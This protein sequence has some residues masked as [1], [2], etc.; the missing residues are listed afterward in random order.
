MSQSWDTE[1][2]GLVNGEVRTETSAVEICDQSN[3]CTLTFAFGRSFETDGD[4]DSKDDD[5]DL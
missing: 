2:V 5:E 1:P 4:K 3:K